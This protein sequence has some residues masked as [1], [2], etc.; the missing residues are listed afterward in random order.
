MY[1]HT[2]GQNTHN[3]SMEH[4]VI[5]LDIQ[6][7]ETNITGCL[8]F[9]FLTYHCVLYNETSWCQPDSQGTP[10]FN[11]SASSDQTSRPTTSSVHSQASDQTLSQ[12]SKAPTTAGDQDKTPPN[13]QT[14]LL[15]Q[16]TVSNQ[17]HSETINDLQRSDQLSLQQSQEN[18]TVGV[19]DHFNKTPPNNQ[20]HLQNL[21]A[22]NDQTKVRT[23]Q[24]H[25]QTPS[26]ALSKANIT[27]GDQSHLNITPP[28]NQA[29]QEAV[30]DQTYSRAANDQGDLQRSDQPN[31]QR[32]KENTVA[33]ES[34][35]L[36]L[37]TGT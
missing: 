12:Q 5:V 31:S 28:N 37:N 21:S 17:V 35:S 11:F 2:Y 10:L 27:A 23:N 29:S 9:R 6:I 7:S 8:S 32:L 14:Y 4:V 26:Q 25:L 16:K 22:S 30:N 13:N 34:H 24:V 19:Q 3:Y 15:S 33:D 1:V 20:S 36:S 18:A